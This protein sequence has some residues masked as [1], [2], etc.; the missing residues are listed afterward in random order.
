MLMLAEVRR[1]YDDNLEHAVFGVPNTRGRQSLPCLMTFDKAYKHGTVTRIEQSYLAET[2]R[3]HNARSDFLKSTPAGR[4]VDQDSPFASKSCSCCKQG[5]VR[6]ELVYEK[7]DE[8][9]ESN[10]GTYYQFWSR[11]NFGGGRRNK[12]C[13][14]CKLRHMASLL[15]RV[16]IE[17]GSPVAEKVTPP[18]DD[19]DGREKEAPH[20]E[21]DRTN[22]DDEVP[23]ASAAFKARIAKALE[24]MCDHGEGEGVSE[25]VAKVL[26]LLHAGDLSAL[27]RDSLAGK[28]RPSDDVVGRIKGV[29]EAALPKL[30][31]NAMHAAK[32]GT[33]NSLNA[34]TS[35]GANAEA[36]S[37]NA[38]PGEKDIT[39]VPGTQGDDCADVANVESFAQDGSLWNDHFKLGA[40]TF[41]QVDEETPSLQSRGYVSD[42]IAA[43]DPNGRYPAACSLGGADYTFMVEDCSVH[44]VMVF[45]GSENTYVKPRGYAAAVAHFRPG[46]A[47]TE[48]RHARIYFDVDVPGFGSAHCFYEGDV[49]GTHRCAH[50]YGSLVVLPGREVYSGFFSS[51]HCGELEDID[52]PTMGCCVQ[53]RGVLGG[54]SGSSISEVV[55]RYMRHRMYWFRVW[56][57]MRQE[58]DGSQ[59][60][61]ESRHYKD[62]RHESVSV[63]HDEVWKPLLPEAPDGQPVPPASI[64]ERLGAIANHDPANDAIMEEP[65]G[66]ARRW[67]G[68]LSL[69][70]QSVLA[71]EKL[72]C[73]NGTRF[74]HVSQWHTGESGYEFYDSIVVSTL[75]APR[76]R[77]RVRAPAEDLKRTV[78][79]GTHDLT[80]GVVFLPD[81][82]SPVF[83]D[84]MKLQNVRAIMYVPALHQHSR[85]HGGKKFTRC[86]VFFQGPDAG[87]GGDVDGGKYC[88]LMRGLPIQ[89]HDEHAARHF[90]CHWRLALAQPNTVVLLETVLERF[91]LR[92]H[93]FS[94]MLHLLLLKDIVSEDKARRVDGEGDDQSVVFPLA[95]HVFGLHGL[96]VQLEELYPLDKEEEL[97]TPPE[98]TEGDITHATLVERQLMSY[99]DW[100]VGH[101]SQTFDG[102]NYVMPEPKLG[103]ANGTEIEPLTLGD[104]NFYLYY[105]RRNSKKNRK[106]LNVRRVKFV[107][108]CPVTPFRLEILTNGRARTRSAQE[109]AS[110]TL[111]LTCLGVTVSWMLEHYHRA[112][113]WMAM[114]GRWR[115]HCFSDNMEPCDGNTGTFP[116][117]DPE[118]KGRVIS[119]KHNTWLDIGKMGHTLGSE[120]ASCVGNSVT[121]VLLFDAGWQA[122]Q[123][124]D[125]GA[126]ADV[127]NWPPW[128]PWE[129]VPRRLQGLNKC[130][131]VGRTYKAKSVPLS[132][133]STLE[134]GG[135]GSLLLTSSLGRQRLFDA[136]VRAMVAQPVDLKTGWARHVVAHIADEKGMWSVHD[137]DEA[138]VVLSEGPSNDTSGVLAAWTVDVSVSTRGCD[139]P[140][141]KK[142][143]LRKSSGKFAFPACPTPR[144]ASAHAVRLSV[145]AAFGE[146]ARSYPWVGVFNVVAA[147]KVVG[148]IPDIVASVSPCLLW[149]ELTSFFLCEVRDLPPLEFDTVLYESLWDP[150]RR[151]DAEANHVHLLIARSGAAPWCPETIYVMR[152]RN[153]QWEVYDPAVRDYVKIYK[154]KK[155]LGCL[156]VGSVARL[157]TAKEPEGNVG[158]EQWGTNGPYR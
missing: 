19:A 2:I 38:A 118:A 4:V 16:T 62:G 45:D 36:G 151:E 23:G 126:L 137:T 141:K 86:R 144:E 155:P 156:V 109:G 63:A 124:V 83:D 115:P 85:R 147:A 75:P 3:V 103:A 68:H 150:L 20:G 53:D 49:D 157:V 90:P 140:P 121:E 95:D 50:G 44:G 101:G 158:I 47:A 152:C 116:V 127:E 15:P 108:R 107:P 128:M 13:G 18:D 39:V 29:L 60:I 8:D 6:G 21:D 120:M 102:F 113:V 105:D 10:V 149:E 135:Y 143:V 71:C 138:P 56:F 37:M 146:H 54:E 76:S 93:G 129:S 61:L 97:W 57:P 98:R 33:M 100:S 104:N 1:L 34:R 142:Q 130:S 48:Y 55:G 117:Y 87:E 43:L 122:R 132:R 92:V 51:L 119:W 89:M 70:P 131:D 88:Q 106:L 153:R 25:E 81:G 14:L 27:C 136:G 59:C 52:A 7:P 133:G 73:P 125:R 139:P 154:T 148:D 77:S 74:S 112:V 78:S 91:P 17:G 111:A 58:E 72:C 67:R 64:L 41:L 94:Q 12:T 26:D 99:D 114:D 22:Q 42:S 9:D 24:S 35:T 145:L 28:W 80:G 79:I 123:A 96:W 46:T 69:R 5:V 65:P 82:E 66:F 84:L 31:V 110:E 30:L 134:R 40:R 11:S 32:T